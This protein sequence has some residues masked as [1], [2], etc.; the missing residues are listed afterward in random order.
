MTNR[1]KLKSK[2]RILAGTGPFEPTDAQLDQIIKDIKALRKT[3]APSDRDW[4]DAVKMHVPSAGTYKYAGVD[5][6][7]LLQ[8]LDKIENET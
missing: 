8:L 3:R 7:D 6:S 2:L 5:M 4:I 1:E